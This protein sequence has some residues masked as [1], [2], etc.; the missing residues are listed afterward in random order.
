MDFNKENEK[1]LFMEHMYQCSGRANPEHPMHGLFTN[2]WLEFCLNE[3]G[4]V[5]R[6]M[7]FDRLRAVEEFVKQ[8]EANKE[9]FITTLH[10]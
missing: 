1:A 4:P 8:Q 3:A 9:E 2:L 5:C 10:D 7:Y 6:D